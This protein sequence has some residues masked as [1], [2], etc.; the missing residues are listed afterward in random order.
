MSDN[1]LSRSKTIEELRAADPEFRFSL[2]I[3]TRT[4]MR[5]GNAILQMEDGVLVRVA[6]G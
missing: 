3:V 5:E 1:I 6:L 4:Y 2:S